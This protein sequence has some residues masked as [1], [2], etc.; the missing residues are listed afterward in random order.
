MRSIVSQRIDADEDALCLLQISVHAGMLELAVALQDEVLDVLRIL[1]FG[2]P[3]ASSAAS[4]GP[5]PK[6]IVTGHSA[7]A[8]I[9]GLL[10][11]NI[12]RSNENGVLT[13]CE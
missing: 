13:P 4:E 2:R 9:S 5:Q 10:L 3:G 7:G 12:L 6:L 11:F 8:A 1:Q